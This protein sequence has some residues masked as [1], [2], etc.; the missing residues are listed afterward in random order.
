MIKFTD[1]TVTTC[2]LAQ[3]I[4]VEGDKRLCGSTE[5]HG[6]SNIVQTPN[7]N[8]KTCFKK[9][10]GPDEK[11]DIEQIVKKCSTSY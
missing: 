5:L 7:I 10:V 9:F 11:V 1:G 3:R 8:M 4:K 2:F 6:Y